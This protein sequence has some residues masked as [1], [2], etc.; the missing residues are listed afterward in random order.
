MPSKEEDLLEVKKAAS[1]KGLVNQRGVYRERMNICD[2]CDRFFR[3]TKQ[4]KECGC[5]MFLKARI[6]SMSCPIG[7]WGV[8]EPCEDCNQ[9]VQL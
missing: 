8:A 1:I 9:Q 6:A 4:C 3:L 5:F 2:E 7:K